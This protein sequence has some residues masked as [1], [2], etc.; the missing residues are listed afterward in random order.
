MAKKGSRASERKGKIAYG[1]SH[2]STAKLLA[3]LIGFPMTVM[4]YQVAQAE[5][6]S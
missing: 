4:D 5:V 1:S 3:K 2:V 6:A